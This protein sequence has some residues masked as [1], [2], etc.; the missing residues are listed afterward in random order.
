M[1]ITETN[2]DNFVK[3]SE[4]DPDLIKEISEDEEAKTLLTC[5]ECGMCTSSCPIAEQFPLQPHQMTHLASFGVG[6]L[7]LNEYAL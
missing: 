3:S 4:L 1:A 6:R 2:H 7:I 5:F